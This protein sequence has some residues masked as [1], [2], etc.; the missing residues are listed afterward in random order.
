MNEKKSSLNI[1]NSKNVSIQIVKFGIVGLS[2]TA[3]YLMVYYVLIYFEFNYILSNVIAFVLSVLNAYF[4]NN[5]YVFIKKRF[6]N[7][8]PFLKTFFSYSMTFILSNV[9]FFILINYFFISKWVAPIINLF[10][11]I[12]LNFLLIKFWAM[13]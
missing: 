7:L 9:L 11:I 13:K 2:N 12:P 3:I 10:V 8:E 1:K 4:W 6:S 5:K